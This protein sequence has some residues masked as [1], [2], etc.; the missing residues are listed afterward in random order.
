MASQLTSLLARA[1]IDDHT[2]AL[3]AA[4]AALAAKPKD[5]TAQHT[6]VTALLRLER[7][8]DAL[9]VLASGGDALEERCVLGKSYALYRTGALEEALALLKKYD[10][11]ADRALR[12]VAAQVAYRSERFDEAVAL[13]GSL[14]AEQ[15]GGNVG[16]DTDLKINLLATHAQLEWQGRGDLV[17]EKSKSPGREDLEA[18]ETAY[19]AGCACVARGDLAKAAFL[20]KRAADLCE[21]TEDLGEED[22]KVEMLPIVLQRAYVLALIGQKEEAAALQNGIESYE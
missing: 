10:D 1:S 11:T 14:V 4:D 5:P 16:E 9:R 12:H 6:K 18:F 8:D 3:A 21:A 2:E 17:P 20:L 19:N 13:Y 15:G 7:Y 22:K